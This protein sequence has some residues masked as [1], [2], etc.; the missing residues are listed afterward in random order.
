MAE[1]IKM[2]FYLEECMQFLM[3]VFFIIVGIMDCGLMQHTPGDIKRPCN[4][5]GELVEP[6][7]LEKH[8]IVQTHFKKW[9][10][11]KKGIL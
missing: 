10:G 1:L 2:P 8:E 11:N 3:A 7:T 5:Y 6:K 4:N 9:Q